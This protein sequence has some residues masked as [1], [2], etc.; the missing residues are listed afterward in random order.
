MDDVRNP[1]EYGP[2]DCLSVLMAHG[3]RVALRWKG[4]VRWYLLDGQ[5]VT[6]RELEDRAEDCEPLRYRITPRA[7]LE[8]S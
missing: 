1:V 8:N 5:R 3:H 7:H 4:G 2:R 6:W